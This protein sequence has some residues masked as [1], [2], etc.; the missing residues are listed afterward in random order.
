VGSSEGKLR[1]KDGATA[2]EVHKVTA[3]DPIDDITTIPHS[4]KHAALIRVLGAKLAHEEA[5]CGLVDIMDMLAYG[6]V[7]DGPSNFHQESLVDPR[8]RPHRSKI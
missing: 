7:D 8:V 2:G 1:D 3:C 6:E 5:P 4:F